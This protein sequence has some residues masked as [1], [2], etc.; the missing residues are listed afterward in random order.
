MRTNLK[1]F[2]LSLAAVVT[3]A[4]I[5]ISASAQSPQSCYEGYVYL[6]EKEY[7]KSVSKLS[8]CLKSNNLTTDSR[9][10][11]YYNRSVSY[12]FLFEEQEYV[13]K[14]SNKAEKYLYKAVEDIEKSID[15][16]PTGNAKAYCMRGWIYLELSFGF[17]GYED[18]DKGIAMGAPKHLC[19]DS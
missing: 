13:K 1:T 10:L 17:D 12:F 9:A 4:S 11:A 19:D 5:H 3:L 8:N 7:K 6:G 14:N 16:D 15:L 18:L 2:L